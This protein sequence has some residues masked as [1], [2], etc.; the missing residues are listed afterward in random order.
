MRKS[1]LR[2]GWQ[3]FW[4]WHIG[5]SD[6]HIHVHIRS[7][8][9]AWT[10]TSFRKKFSISLKDNSTLTLGTFM[11]LGLA[12]EINPKVWIEQFTSWERISQAASA[13]S[14]LLSTYKDN[15]K[16]KYPEGILSE[17]LEMQLLHG[18]QQPSSVHPFHQYERLFWY[19]MSELTKG[20]TEL[21]TQLGSSSYLQPF[22]IFWEL[23]TA[24]WET[25]F[26]VIQ[27]QLFYFSLCNN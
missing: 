6:S 10:Q 1:S 11:K 7:L 13:D 19:K 5:L 27:L 15:F 9:H 20:K 22:I 23:I 24:Q 26:Y 4:V 3:G 8:T 12:V 2:G 18:I 21:T 17:L 14:V 25:E 16:S